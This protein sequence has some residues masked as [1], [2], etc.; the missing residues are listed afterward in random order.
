[1][2]IEHLAIQ[3]RRGK[4]SLRSV[5]HTGWECVEIEDLG[6]PYAVCEMCEVQE[7]R[8]LHYMR[9][10]TFTSVLA[11]GCVC[12]GHME[13]DHVSAER[14]DNLMKSRAQKRRRWLSRRWKVSAKGN[15][16]LVTDGFRVTVYPLRNSWEVTVAAVDDSYLHQ[17]R[18]AFAT[19]DLAKLA[20]FDLVSKILAQRAA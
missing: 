20:G 11:V 4:W 10:P 9:H 19:Q 6:G 5:P 16:W 14:R 7:I 2:G 18:R 1:M 3:N 15:D 17:S 13:T 12:A 8:Y